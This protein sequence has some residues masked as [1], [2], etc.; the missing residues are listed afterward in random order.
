MI[1]TQEKE[2]TII[3]IHADLYHAVTRADS[4]GMD[5]IT[6]RPGKVPGFRGHEKRGK[7]NIFPSGF[8]NPFHV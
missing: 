7:Q 2:K 3:F 1:K 5:G 6:S 8:I 4:Q